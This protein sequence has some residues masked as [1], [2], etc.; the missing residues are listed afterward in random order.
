MPTVKI[1]Y[2]GKVT[3]HLKYKMSKE[4]VNAAQEDKGLRREIAKVFQAANRR[5]QNVEA[6]GLYSPAVAA[7]NKGGV[8]GYSKF[9]VKMFQG[10]G[11]WQALKEEYGKAIAF[12]NQPT[13]MASG[14]RQYNEAIRKR[15]NL[16]ESEYK[17][18]S[19]SFTGKLDSISGTSFIDNYM[20]Q[21]KDFSGDFEANAKSAS[22]AMESEALQL[23]EEL[24]RN[25]ESEAEQ[26]AS[27][28]EAMIDTSIETMLKGFGM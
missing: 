25:I 26:A 9:S 1:E 22:T 2:A 3:K 21:Y 15:Y 12:L 20:K 5:I 6:T 28:I 10:S 8:S 14:T 27:D 23:E 19:D 11:S 18:L 17:A 13:S 7:L 24:Q 4:I 16:T